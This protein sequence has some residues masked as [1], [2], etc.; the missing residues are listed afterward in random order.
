ME[1]ASY[2]ASHMDS[3][4]LLLVAV[5][6]VIVVRHRHVENGWTVN[7]LAGY[8]PQIATDNTVQQ[9]RFST[10]NSLHSLNLVFCHASILCAKQQ[11]RHGWLHDVGDRPR[12]LPPPQPGRS[13]G[14]G[15]EG[16][17]GGRA[18]G[19]LRRPATCSQPETACTI[20]RLLQY[21]LDT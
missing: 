4:G 13:Q 2:H 21:A 16:W 15:G 11:S 6:D 17:V 10:V 8:F 3:A 5:G 12:Q 20:H 14:R 18:G 9:L 19:E 1:S 7:F